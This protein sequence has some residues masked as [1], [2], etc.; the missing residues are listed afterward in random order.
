MAAR[1]RYWKVR[2][3]TNPS[4]HSPIA[5]CSRRP[6]KQSATDAATSTDHSSTSE[7]QHVLRTD[8]GF[9]TMTR[10]KASRGTRMGR[11][12]KVPTDS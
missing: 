11:P 5:G 10:S 1:E 7:L 9:T 12:L 3:E 2:L 6:T 4:S 8:T